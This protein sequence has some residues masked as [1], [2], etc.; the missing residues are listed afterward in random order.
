MLH[1]GTARFALDHPN[2]RSLHSRPVPRTGGVALWI[3]VAMAWTISWH[4]VAWPLAMALG[5]LVIVSLWDDF[6]SLPAWSRLAIQL[7]AATGYVATTL[8]ALGVTSILAVLFLVWMA[9]LYNFMDGSDG[10]AGGMAVIGFGSYALAAW[11]G[12]NIWLVALCAPVAAAALAFLL[13]NFHPAKVFLGDAGSVPL[14]FLAAALG[15]AGW[16]E[17]LW[18]LWFPFAV[19]AAFVVDASVTLGKRLL[20]GEKVWQAHREHYYQR[21]VR[22]GWG[23]RKTALVEYGLMLACGISAVMAIQWSSMAQMVFLVG[24]GG[25]LTILMRVV[26][27]RWSAF[28]KLER[29]A[30]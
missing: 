23:H 17:G 20:R 9:N 30:G 6:V 29:Q 5:L 22:M 25:V 12:G 21:L 8:P 4:G 15:L 26:D 18:P 28:L 7:L 11:L 1:S 16:N 14:G 3:G 19:F 2:A 27:V 24:W 13:F 10:L